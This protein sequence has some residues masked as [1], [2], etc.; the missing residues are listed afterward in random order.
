MIKYCIISA[1]FFFLNKN[2]LNQIHWKKTTKITWA[3][4]KGSSKGQ[5]SHSAMTV[6]N[7]SWKELKSQNKIIGLVVQ[8]SFNKKKSWVKIKSKNDYL[9]NHEQKHFDLSEV[10]AR[11]MIRY[12]EKESKMSISRVD[13]IFRRTN[14]KRMKMQKEYD[15]E[16]NHSR[17]TT[18]QTIWDEKIT[19]LLEKVSSYSSDTLLFRTPVLSSEFYYN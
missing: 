14:K 1:L 6:V 7:F 19:D 3:D 2:D 5:S 8:N 10:F 15:K 4:F 16:T 12:L 13:K 18:N 11:Q 9:L 17:N